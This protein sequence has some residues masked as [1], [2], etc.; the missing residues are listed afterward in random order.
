MKEEYE[1]EKY[2]KDYFECYARITLETCFDSKLKALSHLDSPDF[3]SVELYFKK[4]IHGLAN[5]QNSP[6]L[7]FSY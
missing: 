2:S 6:S 7:Y 5:S 4:A 3:Q 1:N